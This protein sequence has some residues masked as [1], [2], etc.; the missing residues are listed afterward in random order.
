MTAIAN[1]NAHGVSTEVL[2][3]VLATTDHRPEILGKKGKA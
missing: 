1:G 3:Q 2:I